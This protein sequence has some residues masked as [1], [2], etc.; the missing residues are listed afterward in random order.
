LAR[1]IWLGWVLLAV[2]TATG[3]YRAAAGADGAA[4][5]LDQG[6]APRVVTP[7]GD[8]RAIALQP[9]GKAVI[10]GDFLW[11]DGTSRHRIA[12]LEADG[13]VDTTFDPG[14]GADNSVYALAL[15]PDGKIIVGGTFGSIDGIAREGIARLNADGTLDTAFDPRMEGNVYTLAVQPDG[16]V[17]VGGGF[18]IIAGAERS[19]IARLEP[20]GAVDAEFLPLRTSSPGTQTYFREVYAL[21]L[22]PD[23]KVL[24]GG[25][26]SQD[27]GT[28]PNLSNVVRLNAD[29]T[30]DPSFDADTGANS[31]VWAIVLQ[32]DGKVILGG[33][34][35]SVNGIA[36]GHL[37]RLDAD[38]QVDASFDPIS[39]VWQPITEVL[40]LALQPDGKLIIGGDFKSISR[41]VTKHRIARLNRDGSVD[42]TFAGKGAD[43][44][45]RALAQRPDGSV[46]VGGLFGRIHDADRECIAELH[47]DGTPDATF[48]PLVATT[49]IVKALALQPDGKVIL[50]GLFGSIDGIPRS[51]VARLNRDGTLDTSFNPVGWAANVVPINVGDTVTA[52]A[53]QPDGRV[54]VA[55]EPEAQALPLRGGIERRNPDGSLDTSFNCGTGAN[56]TILS[57]ALQPDGKILL[58]G[59]FTQFDGTPRTS[60]ARLQNDGS[61]DITFNPG[62]E[63]GD[64]VLTLAPQPDGKVIIG[65]HLQSVNGI[66]RDSIA[67]LNSD[68]TV[69]HSFDP[70]SLFNPSST[71]CA[72]TLQPNSKVLVGGRFWSVG[73]KYQPALTRLNA[74]GS[75]D[76]T[77][78]GLDAPFDGEAVCAMALQ[79]DGKIIVGGTFSHI[80]RVPRNNIARLNADGSLDSAFEAS[81][82]ADNEHV[83]ALA[84]QPGGGVILG[85]ML[86]SVNGSP[87]TGIARLFAPAD[88][89]RVRLRRR[90]TGS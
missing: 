13:T 57:M 27:N 67:R 14:T 42:P 66:P 16:A 75:L 6:F 83:Y 17:L 71:V 51:S 65:G 45:V 77:F 86:Q 79:P 89:P 46:V 21:V 78:A 60:I 29:G 28:D 38:G 7:R 54:I 70:G 5:A 61:L 58:G 50:G 32:V 2:T 48:A 9:D 68:G 35:T 25:T 44:T 18:S 53:V 22:Q 59:T 39:Y 72:L 64:G 40:A 82:G 36:R 19:C 31:F 24:A 10:G 88:P 47:N 63:P 80:G 33:R 87:R 84:L 43:L 3:G 34:F 41:G 26:L 49:G 90:M 4:G 52:L 37:A 69:D 81:T 20:N 30:L 76:A 74:D 56:S 62:M 8:V 11:I 85:G 15:Q 55:G 23:G 73:G 1:R 12:R